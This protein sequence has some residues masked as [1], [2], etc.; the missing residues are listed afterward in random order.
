MVCHLI[1]Y[2]VW[3][4]YVGVG[5]AV[6]ASHGD[7]DGVSHAGPLVSAI[8]TVLLWPLVFTR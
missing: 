5:L 2:L 6:A 4:V 8:A 1:N 7:L 3:G